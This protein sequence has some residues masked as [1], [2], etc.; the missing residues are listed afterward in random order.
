MAALKNAGRS[1][2]TLYL[3]DVG[4]GWPANK[5]GVAFLTAVESFLALH[6]KR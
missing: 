2:D 5:P 6:L 3:R 1:F 4:H